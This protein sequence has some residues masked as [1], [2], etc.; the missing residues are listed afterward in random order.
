MSEET[1]TFAGGAEG[2]ALHDAE[3]SS[4]RRCYGEA[5]PGTAVLLVIAFHHQ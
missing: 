3:S 4:G 2:N 1:T 5:D